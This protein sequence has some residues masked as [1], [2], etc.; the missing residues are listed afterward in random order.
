MHREPNTKFDIQATLP[1]GPYKIN[2]LIVDW[3][4][5]GHLADRR[6]S[7]TER[8]DKLLQSWDPKSVHVLGSPFLH[9]KADLHRLSL[10]AN[11][12]SWTQLQTVTMLNAVVLGFGN[13]SIVPGGHS[14]FKVT[15]NLSASFRTSIPFQTYTGGYLAAPTHQ[16]PPSWW[17]EPAEQILGCL[18]TSISRTQPSL[19]RGE[20]EVQVASFQEATDLLA[21]LASSDPVHAQSK[22][23]DSQRIKLGCARLDF[24][25]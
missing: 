13:Q 22:A 20:V 14:P 25:G 18:S 12:L 11:L 17:I 3:R 5:E 21:Q 9:H 1:G 8:L 16:P 10:P 2:R 24:G 4:Q 15:I 7:R 19:A 6:R 23:L